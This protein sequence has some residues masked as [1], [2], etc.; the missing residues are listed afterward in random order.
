MGI[1]SEKKAE[2]PHGN[3]EIEQGEDFVA[4]ITGVQQYKTGD[5]EYPNDGWNV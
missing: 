1:I 4:T 2:E 5:G 3:K